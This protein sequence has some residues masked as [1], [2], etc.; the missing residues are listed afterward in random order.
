MALQ[1]SKA[2]GWPMS[3]VKTLYHCFEFDRDFDSKFS[4]THSAESIDPQWPNFT[5]HVKGHCRMQAKMGQ[6]RRS[7]R[8]RSKSFWQRLWL[9]KNY[10]RKSSYLT[11]ELSTDNDLNHRIIRV[12][13]DRV[14]S[15]QSQCKVERMINSRIFYSPD[16]FT[17]YLINFIC[18]CTWILV[19]NSNI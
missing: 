6:D 16:Y 12:E 10:P 13:T 14:G 3:L 11:L 5:P 1:G 9:A 19:I 8:S 2:C 17:C 4:K 18:Y 15:K 7:S